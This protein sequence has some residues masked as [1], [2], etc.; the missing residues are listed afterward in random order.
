MLFLH[1]NQAA[2]RFHRIDTDRNG[3]ITCTEAF[4]WNEEAFLGEAF[5]PKHIV[6]PFGVRSAAEAC[7]FLEESDGDKPWTSKLKKNVNM[8][9]EIEDDG[10]VYPNEFD[11]EIRKLEDFKA[12]M[13]DVLL[14]QLFIEGS[15]FFF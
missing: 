12:L 8:L 1:I 3:Y 11:D 4:E 13:D 2:I 14:H 5:D 6:H 15:K 10:R 9:R 7:K